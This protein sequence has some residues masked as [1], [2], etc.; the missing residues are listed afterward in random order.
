MV[1]ADVSSQI[2]ALKEKLSDLTAEKDSLHLQIKIE[3]NNLVLNN[4]SYE[5]AIKHEK[6]VVTKLREELKSVI[7]NATQEIDFN[8]NKMEEKNLEITDLHQQVKDLT[9]Q[10]SS[11]QEENLSLKAQIANMYDEQTFKANR[12]VAEAEK[13]ENTTGSNFAILIGTSNITRVDEKR[14]THAIE[15]KKI[16]SYTVNDAKQKISSLTTKPNIII[17]H[18]LTNDIQSKD[19]KTCV[20]EMQL[21]VED[22][23]QKWPEITI[24]ISLTT[25]RNDGVIHHTNGQIVNAMLRQ[26]YNQH[27]KVY[28][29]DHSN[30]CHDGLPISDCLSDDGYHLSDKGVTQLA[31]NIRRAIHSVLGIPLPNRRDRSRSRGRGR[32]RGRGQGRGQGHGH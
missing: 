30:M 11:L 17:L 29:V 22:V 31:G 18:I 19:P 14:L 23:I 1:S 20:S 16:I 32:G 4:E 21:L 6:S 25:P 9:A 10:V 28:L 5:S 7:T 12:H 24:I 27:G 2:K 13:P 15:I 3:R 26:T 8:S